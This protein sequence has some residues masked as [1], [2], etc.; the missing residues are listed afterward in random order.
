MHTEFTE[1]KPTH[2]NN[3][4]PAAAPLGIATLIN[5]HFLLQLKLLS[6]GG[7]L[8]SSSIAPKLAELLAI[9]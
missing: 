6:A 3:P 2:F 7:I 4:P 9:T 8:S 5:K 1:I